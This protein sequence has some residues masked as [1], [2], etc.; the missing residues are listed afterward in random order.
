M[1]ARRRAEPCVVG[2]VGEEAI[3]ACW[4]R[5]MPPAARGRACICAACLRAGRG[6]VRAEP[7]Q[8]SLDSGSQVTS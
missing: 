8:A 5:L 2:E 7:L 4:M 1:C 6:A 3:G